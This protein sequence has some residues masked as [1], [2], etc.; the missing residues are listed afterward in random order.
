MHQSIT[1]QLAPLLKEL[2]AGFG[3]GYSAVLFG[4]AA[5][6]DFVARHSDINLMLVLPALDPAAL[7]KLGP[8]FAR[9]R[10]TGNPPPLLLTPAELRRSADA[11]PLEIHDLKAAHL[12]IRGEDPVAG[13]SVRPADLRAAL[14]RDARGKLLRLRQGYAESDGKSDRLTGLARLTV[15]GVLLL[16][17]AVLAL[18]R[19]PVP[20]DPVAMIGDVAALAGFTPGALAELA[21]QRSEGSW[22]CTPERFEA[23]LA[24]VERLVGFLDELHTGDE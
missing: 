11:F 12:V 9:W 10:K 5:R 4:S 19:R 3:T 2:D 24:T 14:E 17:R 21:A 23:Y 20:A 18:T 7:R 16:C 22:R 8:A 13:L 1:D 15:G 6:A